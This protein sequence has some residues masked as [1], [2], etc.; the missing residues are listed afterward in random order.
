M[1]LRR[2][3]TTDCHMWILATSWEWY[4]PRNVGHLLVSNR[5]SVF[6]LANFYASVTHYMLLFVCGQ[7]L[8]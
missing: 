7:S 6:F 2:L 5:L 4:T 1:V 3:P 8:L